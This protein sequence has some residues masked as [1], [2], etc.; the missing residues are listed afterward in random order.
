MGVGGV[1][2]LV[3]QTGRAAAAEGSGSAQGGTA[4]QTDNVRIERIFNIKD[5]RE[6]IR[7][8]DELIER[9]QYLYEFFDRERSV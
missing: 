7:R 5:V 2:K 3:K 4:D 8:L 6:Y 9:K 1:T